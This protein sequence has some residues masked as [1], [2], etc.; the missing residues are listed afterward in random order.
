LPFIP[1]HRNEVFPGSRNIAE[2]RFQNLERKLQGDNILY[3]AYKNFMN[4]YETLG[5]MSIATEPG[6]YF[7]P[8]H[9]VFKPNC[10]SSKI[11]VVFDASTKSASQLSLNQCLY[12]G[13]KLQ[14]DIVD[15]L[16]RFR[17]HQF[18]FTADVC[19]MYRQI[20]VLPEYRGFQ[21]ILWRSSSLDELKEYQLNTVTYGINSAPFLALRVLKDIAD[22]ECVE[23]PEVQN[24]LREQTYVDDICLGADNVN[25]LL[26]L[27]SNL[28]SVLKRAGFDLKKW[29]S[30]TVSV[31]E[32]VPPED[33]VMDSLTFDETVC[34]TTKVL[35]LQWDPSNDIFKFDVHSTTTV[36]TKRA[37]LSTIA[38][39][40]DPIGL[41]AP[42]TFYAKHILHEIW[43]EDLAWD[44]PLPQN[45][46]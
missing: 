16:F 20:L 40:F 6:T 18:V 45:L 32:A 23:F 36:V 15:I 30:N 42:V 7:I 31:L 26:T 35:G 10:P 2:R 33:R 1:K 11:R 27:Q 38:R 17:I 41:L 29:S 34:E 37:V 9:P 21:H 8:H 13:P 44:D 4:E 5:H 28:C 24:G 39:I 43:E 3:T 12:A 19:K 22:H 46:H 25:E 14:L